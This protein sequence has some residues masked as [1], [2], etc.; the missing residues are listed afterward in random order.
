M[1]LAGNVHSAACE[2]FR[3]MLTMPDEAGVSTSVSK[4]L[5]PSAGSLVEGAASEHSSA[6]ECESHWP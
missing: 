6:E 4:I 5:V 1:L 2:P 3:P